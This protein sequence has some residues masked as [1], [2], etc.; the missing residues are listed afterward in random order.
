L[1]V[2]VGNN[3]VSQFSG[4]GLTSSGKRLCVRAR[5]SYRE[6]AETA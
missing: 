4:H 5:P 6:P 2:G 1:S 3:G